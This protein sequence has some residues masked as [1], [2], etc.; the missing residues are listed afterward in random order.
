MTTFVAPSLAVNVLVTTASSAKYPVTDRK[1]FEE[2]DL[3]AKICYTGFAVERPSRTAKTAKRQVPS[4]SGALV[5]M[6]RQ[7]HAEIFNIST[8]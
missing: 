3:P 7:D 1:N 5:S 6:A 8:V 2:F 4:I